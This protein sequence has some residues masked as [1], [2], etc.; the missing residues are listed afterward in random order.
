[1]PDKKPVLLTRNL[2]GTPKR[3]VEAK[4][5]YLTDE[6]GKKY[7]DA[8]GGVAVV[9]I[10]HGVEEVAEAMYQQA[11]KVDFVYGGSVVADSRTEL[12]DRLARFA[13]EGMGHVFFC[14]GGSEATESAVKAARQFHIETGRPSKHK[15]IARWLSYHGNT[16]GGL[17]LSGRP[18][19]RAYC[20]PYLLDFPHIAPPNC[21]RCWFGKTYPECGM[22]CAWELE[23]AIKLEGPDDVAAFIAEP[24]IGTTVTAV[25]P[26]KEYYKIIREICDRYNVLMIMD[27]VITGVGRTGRNW[28]IEHYD[29]TPDIIAVA[30]GLSGGYAPIGA[31][32]V[33]DRVFD[34]YYSGSGQFWHSF[35]FGGNPVSCAAGNAV[36]KYIED[37]KLVDRAAVMGARL[38]DLLKKRLSA[39]PLVGAVRGTGMLIGLEFVKGK[40][41]HEPFSAESQVIEK[42]CAQAF[43]QGL[44]VVGG[45]R[46]SVD[47]VLG[48]HI[49][50]TPPFILTDSEAD[51]LA[52]KLEAALDKVCQ[53][54][55][56]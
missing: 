11:L 23:R 38:L 32:L 15:V 40:K 7:L 27:E 26:P 25:A 36:L 50:I 21:Y 3:I 18:S 10:G 34:A 17:S 45:I 5:C 46:G 14:S 56:L 20:A 28:G 33:N 48:D 54:L 35:T 41:T 39:H 1:M 24:I 16:I 22:Q 4:G 2:R 53:D 30:K 43:D 55:G 49:Q 44:L 12:G 51:E 52:G 29:V 13:P 19:W 6:G 8:A 37:H 47:G 42:V 9:N 31:V